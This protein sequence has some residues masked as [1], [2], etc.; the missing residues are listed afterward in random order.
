M[1]AAGRTGPLLWWFG[2]L[3]AVTA[4]LAGVALLRG[5][6]DGGSGVL[7]LFAQLW[8]LC[9]IAFLAGSVATWLLVR[10]ARYGPVPPTTPPSAPA[11]PAA[12]PPRHVRAEPPEPPPPAAEPA[13]ANLDTHRDDLARH[14]GSA[15]AGALDR[16]GV[17]GGPR[18]ADAPPPAP[19]IPAQGGPVDPP[20]REG[21]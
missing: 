3:L 20:P 18:R 7:D 1:G 13:L 10:P 4:L 5:P 6:G 15:A 12:V 14:P 21:G 17:A 9:A 19:R 8:F 11:A 16:L 2:A